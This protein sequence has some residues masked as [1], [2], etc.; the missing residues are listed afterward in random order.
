MDDLRHPVGAIGL[1]AAGEEVSGRQAKR[2]RR[3]AR[4]VAKESGFTPENVW[5]TAFSNLRPKPKWM[6]GW[7]WAKLLAWMF[8]K[9]P[10]SEIREDLKERQDDE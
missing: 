9:V 7:L 2:L 5:K 6:P 4:R 1:P 3:V 10:E 8:F